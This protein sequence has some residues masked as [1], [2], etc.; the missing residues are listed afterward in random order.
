MNKQKIRSLILVFLM[1]AFFAIAGG[2][3]IAQTTMDETKSIDMD[4]YLS[5]L[6]TVEA[7]DVVVSYSG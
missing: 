4:A 6:L 5:S 7:G 2:T 1:L 3:A